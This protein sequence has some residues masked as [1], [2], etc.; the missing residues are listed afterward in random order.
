MFVLVLVLW[1][2]LVMPDH[3]D[4]I[5]KVTL[6]EVFHR[7]STLALSFITS[8]PFDRTLGQIFD[9]FSYNDIS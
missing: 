1:I 2:L 3:M 4:H 5:P 7:L 8:I 9:T 6:C